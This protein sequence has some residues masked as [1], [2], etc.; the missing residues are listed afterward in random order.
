MSALAGRDRRAAGPAAGP[1]H[2][3]AGRRRRRSP[4]WSASPSRPPPSTGWPTSS[5]PAA[6]AN[7]RPAPDM[8][9]AES[10]LRAWVATGD[11]QFLDPYY[12]ARKHV[13]REQ[14]VL[15]QYAEQHPSTPGR[16]PARTRRRQLVR[17][18]R[19]AAPRPPRRR[20]HRLAPAVR[21]GGSRSST[22]SARR[23]RRSRP[24][25]TGS[26]QDARRAASRQLPWIV[27]VLSFVARARRC[28]ALL[29]RR[30]AGPGISEPLVDMQRPS[31][32]SRPGTPRPGRPSPV[33]ARSP[34][35][36][37]R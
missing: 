16:R 30:F 19:R 33:R 13:V 4:A 7:A 12:A 27:V 9:H 37:R 26:S 35:S 24:S 6:D 8:T 29:A 11:E 34:R 31:T 23:T 20:G 32:G 36:A 15:Q 18:V 28:R 2:G 5:C 22:G 17:D 10:A 21:A 25:S 14:L 1:R 3:P